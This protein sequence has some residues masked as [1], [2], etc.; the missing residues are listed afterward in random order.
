[1]PVIVVLVMASVIGVGWA[2]KE[3]WR[4]EWTSWLGRG[5][6]VYGVSYLVGFLGVLYASEFGL[7]G[8]AGGRY[9]D[10]PEAVAFGWAMYGVFYSIV[11]LVLVLFLDALSAQRRIA[12]ELPVR[13]RLAL[14][15]Y[16]PLFSFICAVASSGSIVGLLE[17]DFPL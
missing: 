12:L 9:G 5:L 11:P 2:M 1:M 4:P 3:A 16:A 15:C 6:S 7:L 17:R 14:W 8:I 13:S 10:K